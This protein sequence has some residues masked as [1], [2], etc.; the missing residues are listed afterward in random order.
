MLLNSRDLFYVLLVVTS[1]L[2]H[3]CF[4]S[5]VLVSSQERLPSAHVPP[6]KPT[7][8]VTMFD[9]LAPDKQQADSSTG[10][11]PQQLYPSTDAGEAFYCTF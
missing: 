4:L 2:I 9:P 6:L 8:E 1:S 11:V 10:T 7:P 3:S 5:N